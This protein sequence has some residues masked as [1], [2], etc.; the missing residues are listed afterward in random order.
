M[1]GWRPAVF[2]AVVDGQ[3]VQVTGWT[4]AVANSGLYGGGMR[5]APDAAVDDGRLDVVTVSQ[6]SRARFLRS[7]PRVF[8]G[9]HVRQPSVAVRPAERVELDA[10]RPFRVFADGDP[11]AVLPCTLRVRPAAL[12]VLLPGARP[13]CG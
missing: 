9:T 10:D 1:R 3:P 6:T 13:P 12:R 2:S 5:L 4:F 11:V 7:L 8:A